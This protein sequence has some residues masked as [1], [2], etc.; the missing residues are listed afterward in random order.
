MNE[1]TTFEAPDM[2]DVPVMVDLA[3]PQFVSFQNKGLIDLE[4]VTTF[5][6]NVKEIANPFGYFGT[7]MKYAIAILLRNGQKVTLW[8]GKTKHVFTLEEKK[9]RKKPFRVVCMDGENIGFT[10]DLGKNWDMWQVFRELYCNTMDENGW[11]IPRKA[12]PK[13]YH[14]TLIIEGEAFHNAYANKGSIVLERPTIYEL[15]GLLVHT[16]GSDVL[17]Y[18][19]IRVASLEEDNHSA[20][21][22][23]FV[24]KMP[25]TEDRTLEGTYEVKEVFRKLVVKGDN[26]HFIRDFVTC[27]ANTFE[28]RLDL[29]WGD[30]P[31]ETFLKVMSEVDFR[32]VN[33][34]GLLRIYQEATREAK[35][36]VFMDL[37]NIEEQQLEKA[38]VFL[39]LLGYNDVRKYKVRLS[40]ELKPGVMGMAYAGQI[41]LAKMTFLLGTKQ[42]ASTLLEEYL[43]LA[44]GFKDH[45]YQFQNHLFDQ[46]ITLG[47]RL[48]GEPL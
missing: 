14:T 32:D 8:R 45:S 10:D 47:E 24:K 4:A 3:A 38:Y 33:N 35:Q 1:A 9:I 18:N 30:V 48:A 20:M 23:N 37:N 12:E 2:S 26:E 21:T 15:P 27:P 16:G 31:S 13:A 7:G 17:F 19:N 44:K 22:Y 6:V 34:E 36:P 28:S 46:I 43:H 11:T 5:G 25:L 42:V 29:E 40:D 41:I 39:E